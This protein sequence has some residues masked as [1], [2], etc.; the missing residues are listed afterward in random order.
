MSFK[1]PETI[2]T[3]EAAKKVE[4]ELREAAGSNAVESISGP[5]QQVLAVSQGGSENPKAAADE[6]AVVIK[7]AP[8]FELLL[9]AEP[10]DTFMSELI[11][12]FRREIDSNALLTIV[13]RRSLAGGAVLRSKNRIFDFSYRP[14]VLGAKDKLPELLRQATSR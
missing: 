12:W 13:V 14:K 2:A 1:L 7:Q 5:A 11:G 6:L 9:A 3:L 8:K 4:Q 10:H